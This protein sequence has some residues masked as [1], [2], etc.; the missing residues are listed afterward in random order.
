MGPSYTRPLFIEGR[1]HN[2]YHQISTWTKEKNYIVY[3]SKQKKKRNK[4]ITHHLS[5]VRS[6]SNLQWPHFIFLLGFWPQT[7]K[8]TAPSPS[9]IITLQLH[10]PDYSPARFFFLS[11][12]FLSF[13]FQECNYI[14][15]ETFL[16]GCRSLCPVRCLWTDAKGISIR[17]LE[18]WRQ[19]LCPLFCL[20]Q[21]PLRG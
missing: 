13:F 3:S 16:D 18:Q 11:F 5:F 15:W 14:N 4:Q 17:H 1:I 6:L 10:S 2:P 19:G 21:P 8:N 9:L 12:E 20:R 7:L